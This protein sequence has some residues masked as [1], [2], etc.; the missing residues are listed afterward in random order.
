MA[1]SKNPHGE[2]MRTFVSFMMIWWE[3]LSALCVYTPVQSRTPIHVAFSPSDPSL[4]AILQ[5]ALNPF[6][7]ITFSQPIMASGLHGV[8]YLY[9]CVR[10]N[11]KKYYKKTP[12]NNKIVKN[13]FI[14][15]YPVTPTLTFR[16]GQM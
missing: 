6:I 4:F 16:Q 12:W 10:F 13:F 14:I 15:G 5:V 7:S 2:N 3:L 9:L 8:R 1:L 11:S